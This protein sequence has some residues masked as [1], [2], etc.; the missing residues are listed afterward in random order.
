MS[1]IAVLIR[2]PMATHR[3]ARSLYELL[4][5]HV[6]PTYYTRDTSGLP[7]RWIQKAKRSMATLLPAQIHQSQLGSRSGMHN[8]MAPRNVAAPVK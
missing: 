7:T 8:E 2:E 6:V 4:Q 3:A 5:D 1:W